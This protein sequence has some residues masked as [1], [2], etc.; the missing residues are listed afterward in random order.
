MGWHGEV[1][2]QHEVQVLWRGFLDEAHLQQRSETAH[3]LLGLGGEEARYEAQEV[4]RQDG[5]RLITTEVDEA[6]DEA[7]AVNVIVTVLAN[8]VQD[9][10][11]SVRPAAQYRVL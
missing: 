8:V 1:V 6:V 5:A 4:R 10:D 9:D 7:D 3:A 2:A 11:R